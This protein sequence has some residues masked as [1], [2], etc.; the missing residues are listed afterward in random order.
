MLAP[1]GFDIDIGQQIMAAHLYRP[2]PVFKMRWQ[3]NGCIAAR[4]FELKGLKT[5]VSYIKAR[6]INYFTWIFI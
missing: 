1:Y 5:S 3:V 2:R 6:L 4:N